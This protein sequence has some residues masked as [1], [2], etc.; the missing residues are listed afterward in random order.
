MIKI[1]DYFVN[2][3][4]V[5]TQLD[6]FR[7]RISIVTILLSVFTLLVIFE[8]FTREVPLVAKITVVTFLITLLVVKF[9]GFH[10]SL[11]WL[12]IILLEIVSNQYYQLY[13]AQDGV[14]N[15]QLIWSL[16]IIA[17]AALAGGPK[18][19]GFALAVSLLSKNTIAFPY[20]GAL[21]PEDTKFC[22]R[23]VMEWNYAAILVYIAT[24]T[25]EWIL[26]KQ[27]SETLE[28][29]SKL[30]SIFE[31]IEQGIFA[32]NTDGTIDTEYS[33]HLES[34]IDKE[35]IAGL[36]F[37]EVI[38]EKLCLRKNEISQIIEILSLS[39]GQDAINYEV[40]CHI[41]PSELTYDSEK[42]RKVLGV[43]WSS[44][45]KGGR[46]HK[47][48]VSFKD[49]TA[50]KEIADQS[51]I[52]KKQLSLIG[53]IVKMRPDQTNQFMKTAN[54][55]VQESLD[56]MNPEDQSSKKI[57]SHILFK[58]HTL[59]GLSRQF[60]F[61]DLTNLIHQCELNCKRYKDNLNE[62]K[63]ELIA[64]R[65][66][67]NEIQEAVNKIH[68]CDEQ[69]KPSFDIDVLRTLYQEHKLALNEITRLTGKYPDLS[70]NQCLSRLRSCFSNQLKE[71]LYESMH[72]LESL[73]RDLGT[74]VP[75]VHITGEECWLNEEGTRLVSNI[76]VHLLRNTMDHGF[77]DQDKNASGNIFI[78]VIDS[79][80]GTVIQY[81]DDGQGLDLN[82][83]RLRAQ[84]Q[85]L[86][87]GSKTLAD[88]QVA[89]LILSE[90]LSTADKLT[91]ISGQGVGLS[92]VKAF[93][94]DS[95]GQLDVQLDDCLTESG[96]SAF[97]LVITLPKSL[98]DRID[99]VA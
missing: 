70:R 17:L 32:I 48:L 29:K 67:V 96:H 23:M 68:I 77:T 44:V 33:R 25:F 52:F 71:T 90:D 82:K 49:I 56:E 69:N 66:E 26:Y 98:Q 24:W 1:I 47:I 15:V 46:V 76:M 72:I 86:V 21:S 3:K 40:N 59:K 11:G 42:G 9:K 41:L 54:L 58:L 16:A 93:L 18:L 28:V 94:E 87:E 12:P 38:A 65:N 20:C 64:I 22:Q 60:E 91:D 83:I 74:S 10:P 61:E 53:C 78:K 36:P 45:L 34:I 39:L 79:D 97:T 62:I 4:R 88:L 27:M 57:I 43:S 99:Q 2:R 85:G 13:I 80:I 50:E 5:E 73:S 31:N 55:L 95:G 14:I 6:L 81:K 75:S 8:F 19:A 35:Q 7:A 51:V 30:T 84:D 92:A 89:K 37:I 63:N